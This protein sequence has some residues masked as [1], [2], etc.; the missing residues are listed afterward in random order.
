MRAG[1]S[2]P[3]IRT[4]G[5]PTDAATWAGPESP[6][7]R[8]PPL[9]AAASSAAARSRRP[10]WP[11]TWWASGNARSSSSPTACSLGPVITV[12]SKPRSISSP[13]SC[14]KASEG[15]ERGSPG[16]P[17]CRRTGAAGPA[18]GRSWAPPS[19]SS[20]VSSGSSLGR[21]ATPVKWRA[22]PR[23]RWTRWGPSAGGASCGRV[24]RAARGS[25]Q[26]SRAKPTRRA[27]PRASSSDPRGEGALP[28]PLSVDHEVSLESPRRGP[29]R[30]PRAEPALALERKDGGEGLDQGRELWLGCPSDLSGRP[31]VTEGVDERNRLGDVPQVGQPDHEDAF[32]GAGGRHGDG[33]KVVVPCPSMSSGS[34]D[35]GGTTP[36]TGGN[37]QADLHQVGARGARCRRHAVPGLRLVRPRLR[38]G[39]LRGRRGALSPAR[40]RGGAVGPP[41]PPRG[42]AP[43]GRRAP[44][45]RADRE[46]GSAPRERAR[47]GRARR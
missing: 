6:E 39:A 3:A 25:C 17:G 40:S 16:T 19:R 13:A 18:P 9:R 22:S 23:A 8:Q 33:T 2:G 45:R 1:S 21:G 12:T 26:C 4:T 15:H 32:R 35:D 27:R 14:R 29:E 37:D 38:L 28:V 11:T 7:T 5:S 20:G 30:E 34:N 44:R 24:M 42:R 43:G 10:R 47:R 31:T 36:Y 41:R 46:E